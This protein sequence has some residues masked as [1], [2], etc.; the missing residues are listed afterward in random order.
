MSNEDPIRRT[1]MPPIGPDGRRHWSGATSDVPAASDLDNLIVV[2][3]DS[4]N[5]FLSK[6]PQMI[7]R[8]VDNRLQASKNEM[9]GLIAESIGTLRGELRGVL[10]GIRGSVGAETRTRKVEQF[11]FAGE[12]A[13]DSDDGVIDLPTSWRV[14]KT[15]IN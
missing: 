9:R 8:L 3:A 4:L 1:V 13:E 5:H 10:T 2:L 12:R 6:L 15:I 11:R 14:G 7:D